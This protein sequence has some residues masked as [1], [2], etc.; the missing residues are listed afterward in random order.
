MAEPGRTSFV[1]A[2]TV[3]GWSATGGVTLFDVREPHEFAA[4][5]LPGARLM[6]LSAF[7]PAKVRPAAGTRLVLHCAAGI[8]CGRAAEILRATGYD[9]DIFRLEGGL[10]A[11]RAEGLPVER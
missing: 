5:R 3:A 2:R 8:R 11:W 10:K 7:D 9:G 1:D 4:E 6:P